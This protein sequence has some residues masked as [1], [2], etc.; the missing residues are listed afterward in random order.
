[1]LIGFNLTQI[2]CILYRYCSLVVDNNEKNS[3]NFT[4]LRQ[5][6]TQTVT[7]VDELMHKYFFTL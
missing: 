6:N 2:K 4:A 3:N 7:A 1:M 5:F